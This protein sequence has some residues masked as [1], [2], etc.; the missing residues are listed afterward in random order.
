MNSFLSRHQVARLLHATHVESASPS[1]AGL[2]IL[3]DFQK[4]FNF[5]AMVPLNALKTKPSRA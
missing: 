5:E 3:E 2:P 4:G 1:N